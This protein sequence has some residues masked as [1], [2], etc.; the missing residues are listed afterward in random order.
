MNKITRCIIITF[1]TLL[2]AFSSLSFN[3][4]AAAQKG[5]TVNVEPECNYKLF[6]TDGGIVC[7]QDKLITGKDYTLH[8]H[9]STESDPYFVVDEILFENSEKKF[10]DIFNRDTFDFKFTGTEV[11]TVRGH[12][13]YPDKVKVT[14]NFNDAICTSPALYKNE[15]DQISFDVPFRSNLVLSNYSFEKTNYNLIG[16][17]INGD[18]YSLNSTYGPIESNLVIDTRWEEKNI[19]ALDVKATFDVNGNTTLIN[20]IETFKGNSIVLPKCNNALAGYKFVGWNY[21][22]VIYNAGDSFVINNDCSFVAVFEMQNNTKIIVDKNDCD[23]KN[24][25]IIFKYSNGKIV[26]IN[27]VIKGEKIN[28]SFKDNFDSTKYTDFRIES[29]AN[30]IMKNVDVDSLNFS[31]IAGDSNVTFKIHMKAKTEFIISFDANGGKGKM[32]DMTVKAGK[33]FEFIDCEFTK[34][35][36]I[37]DGWEAGGKKVTKIKVT[38]DMT[39]KATWKRFTESKPI[40]RGDDMNPADRNQ[41]DFK[42]SSF[43]LPDTKT[44]IEIPKSSSFTSTTIESDDVKTSISYRVLEDSNTSSD[45]NQFTPIVISEEPKNTSYTSNNVTVSDNTSSTKIIGQAEDVVFTPN[46]THYEETKEEPIY[47]VLAAG[48]VGLMFFLIL[49]LFM[50]TD[51]Y[52]ESDFDEKY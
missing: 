23:D 44:E 33:E 11:V 7:D 40:Y 50:K 19:P 46:Y 2:T 35:G 5:I 39:L 27:N 22:G 51:S 36:Y 31:F 8:I 43:K 38:S 18:N 6:I 14:F 28:V 52:P 10:G 30:G 1:L 42:D 16:Y 34:D 12:M 21:N 41:S 48:L 26:D 49:T 45:A 17:S 29:D 47:Y 24:F 20:P 13:D 4:F 32:D 25:D 3:A 9:K 15:K 37:F